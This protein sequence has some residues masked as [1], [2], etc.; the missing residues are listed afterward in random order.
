MSVF[1]CSEPMTTVPWLYMGRLVVD[2]VVW[3]KMMMDRHNIMNGMA[4]RVMEQRNKI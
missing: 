2:C 3:N 4:D 1:C